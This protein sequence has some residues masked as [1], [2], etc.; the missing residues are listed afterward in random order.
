MEVAAEIVV[1]T[2]S[3]AADEGLGRCVDA[4]AGHERVSLGSAL[5]LVILN[6]EPLALQ[7]IKRL[8]AERTD[9][10]RRHHSI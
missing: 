10:L 2:N 1:A 7:E 9:V 5:K 4:F 8:Q 3:V 6:F